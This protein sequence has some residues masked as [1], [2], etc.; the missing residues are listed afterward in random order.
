MTFDEIKQLVE[1]V[2]ESS[3]GELE[4]GRG[5]DRIR[6]VRQHKPAAVAAPPPTVVAST[7]PV[8]NAPAAQAAQAEAPAGDPETAGLHSITA[9]MVGTYYSA[10]SPDAA[11]FV[12][13]GDHVAQ[14]QTICIIEA[15]KLM[16]EVP[17]DVSGTIV[18]VVGENAQPVEYGQALV[19]VRP[20]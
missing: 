5:D 15:M 9:P 4:I 14:G 1:L 19:R 8:A 7:A 10:P 13:V 2:Q 17:A 20:D 18:E 3:I 11:P 12:E 16:N 6:I